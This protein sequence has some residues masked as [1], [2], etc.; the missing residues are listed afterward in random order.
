MIVRALE[1]PGV[2]HVRSPVHTDAR[3]AFSECFHTGKLAGTGIP[4]RFA[5]DN[6]SRSE[7]HVLRGLHLQ[8]EQPQGKF[9]R[10]LDG[11]I[12][13]VAVDLRDGSD[14]Y[15]RWLGCELEGARGDAL[16]IPPGFAHGFLV[17]SESATVLYKCTTPYHPASEITVCWN[18]ETLGVRW[19]LPDG[20]APT[21]SVRDAAALAFDPRR[22]RL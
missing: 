20:I 17:L 6:L 15:G 8:R 19:P 4:D 3:G 22:D 18:D 5:Q 10:V 13:D 7:Q 2:L 21:L 11:C 12:F 1:L 14:T 9:V 16:W